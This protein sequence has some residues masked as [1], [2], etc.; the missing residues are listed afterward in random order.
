MQI[1]HVKEQFQ[2]EREKSLE[3]ERKA[4]AD[5]L[6]EQQLEQEIQK[7]KEDKERK[8]KENHE[9][10]IIAINEMKQRKHEIDIAMQQRHQQKKDKIYNKVNIIEEK[11]HIVE[12]ERQ[13][14][15]LELKRDNDYK[16]R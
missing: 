16:I 2:R 7:L 5:Y 11:Y 3:Q 12:E 15:A 6:R 8:K 4:K 9:R 10:A 14:K 13:M 1:M